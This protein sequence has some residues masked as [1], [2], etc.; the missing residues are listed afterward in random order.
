MCIRDRIYGAAKPA[1]KIIINSTMNQ[2]NNIPVREYKDNLVPC[3]VYFTFQFNFPDL[4]TE[5]TVSGGTNI[6]SRSVETDWTLTGPASQNSAEISR[7]RTKRAAP[8]SN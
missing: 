7:Q 8:P 2:Y 5:S 6:D 4:C 1:G 3:I